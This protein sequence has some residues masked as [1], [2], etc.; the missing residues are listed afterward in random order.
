MLLVGRISGIDP[1]SDVEI[2]VVPSSSG[3]SI[4]ALEPQSPFGEKV[5][6]LINPNQFTLCWSLWFLWRVYHKVCLHSRCALCN[7]WLKP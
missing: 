7:I 3:I 1:T 5:R 2:A 6:S 4:R